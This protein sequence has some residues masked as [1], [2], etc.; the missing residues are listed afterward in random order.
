MPS[1]S[2]YKDHTFMKMRGQCGVRFLIKFYRF[3][4]DL[5]VNTYEDGKEHSGRLNSL[6]SKVN[7]NFSRKVLLLE[8]ISSF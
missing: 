6:V 7:M 3:W 5:S 2:V 8:S 1:G 4:T